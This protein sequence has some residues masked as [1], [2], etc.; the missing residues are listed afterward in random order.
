[1]SISHL[2]TK[3]QTPSAD[4]KRPE[5][6]AHLSKKMKAFWRS[7]FQRKTLQEY[8]I[9]ILLKAC[10][11]HDRAEQARRIL[12]REGLTYEDRFGQ[13]RSRPEV[14]IERDSRAQYAKLLDQAGLF[15]P[16]FL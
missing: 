12:K 16:Y 15:D 2:K 9:E 4:A 6:P 1:L 5:P 13:P 10:E 8:Q 11:A 3:T 7:V 14:A